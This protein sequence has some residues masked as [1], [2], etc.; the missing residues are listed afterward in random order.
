MIIK[1]YFDDK[2]GWK[3][4]LFSNHLLRFHKTVPEPQETARFNVSQIQPPQS[5]QFRRQAA[6]TM[7]TY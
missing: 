7:S 3:T 2:G 6:T 5:Q 4:S 1:T